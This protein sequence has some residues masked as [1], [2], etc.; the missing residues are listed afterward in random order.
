MVTLAIKLKWKSGTPDT[1]LRGICGLLVFIPLHFPRPEPPSYPWI[2]PK[3][4]PPLLIPRCC[5]YMGLSLLI[6][7]HFSTTNLALTALLSWR[8]DMVP[9]EGLSIAL[10]SVS[11]CSSSSFPVS[12]EPWSDWGAQS[13]APSVWKWTETERSYVCGG[14]RPEENWY[15]PSEPS[16]FSLDSL[17]GTRDLCWCVP[18]WD[19]GKGCYCPFWC[20]LGQRHGSRWR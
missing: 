5:R 1:C 19:S 6:L 14:Q 3:Q 9:H 10:F 12:M 17:W 18:Y 4:P 11:L 13:R 16:D 15:P 7:P 8:V 20:V 2:P